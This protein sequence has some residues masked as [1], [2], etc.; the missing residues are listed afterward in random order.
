MRVFPCL[1][2]FSAGVLCCRAEEFTLLD[3]RVLRDAEVLRQGVDELQIRHEGGIQKVK[4]D[5]LPR[6]LQE[7]FGMTPEQVEARNEELRRAAESRRAARKEEEERHRA[8]LEAAGE[9]P[10]YLGGADVLALVRSVETLGAGEA[11]YL[12]AEWNRR[13]AERLRLESEAARFAGEAASLR[14]AFDAARRKSLRERQ[15][16]DEQK[17]RLTAL[18][19]Q[20]GEALKQ[21]EQL[22]KANE[23]LRQENK[24]LWKA[25]SAWGTNTVVL[26][27]P[28]VVPPVRTFRPAAPVRPARAAAP[29]SGKSAPVR[30]AKVISSQTN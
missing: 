26:P 2:L 10:R 20:L 6:G 29:S 27:S 21:L 8:R 1:L 4:F 16:Q 15:S 30:P 14:A 9:H 22:E 11:E 25:R 3:G 17:A 5:L 23:L 18:R 12:A 13:E 19:E 24:T 28:V 7:R